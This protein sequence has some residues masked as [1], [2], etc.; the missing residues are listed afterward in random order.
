M[1]MDQQRP[2]AERLCPRC[3]KAVSRDAIVCPH[4]V[5]V[6][7][8]PDREAAAEETPL[9][10]PELEDSQPAEPSVPLP[11]VP[12]DQPEYQPT[13]P[14]LPIPAS[15]QEPAPKTPPGYQT[16]APP[17]PLSPPPAPAAAYQPPYQPV[18]PPQQFNNAPFWPRVAALIIDG[19]VL[20][21]PSGLL[22]AATLVLFGVEL[23]L[24]SDEF[25][26]AMQLAQL[27]VSIVQIAYF[28]LM[29]GAY[30][31][32][33]GKMALGMRIVRADGTPIG[34]GV[35][36]GRIVIKLVMQNC[37]CNLFFL[38]VA[39]NNEYRGWHDQIVGTR[40]IYVR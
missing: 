17:P 32:T 27:P 18:A 28:T 20:A 13:G 26:L 25:A 30:G 4:C 22:M 19:F 11:P 21:I 7:P 5:A 8:K 38:S 2:E 33:L 9:D 3:G 29:N 24:E 12:A 40:V 14:T 6:L 23:D 15:Q 31:A 36:L 16:P 10:V 39:I 35:A 1:P 37:T 34:Y